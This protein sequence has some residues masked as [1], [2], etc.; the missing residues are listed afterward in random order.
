VFQNLWINRARISHG[1]VLKHMLAIGCMRAAVAALKN[2]DDK[3]T[4]CA[5][6]SS[7]NIS[8]DQVQYTVALTQHISEL[9]QLAKDLTRLQPKSVEQ[10]IAEL[11]FITMYALET[12]QLANASGTSPAGE[13]FPG[14]CTTN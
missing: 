7:T 14:T 12:K 5:P 1:I 8:S 13:I 10:F 2:R 3:S 6:T 9:E 4:T 11:D